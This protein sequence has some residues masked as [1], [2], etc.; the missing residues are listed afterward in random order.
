MLLTIL[1]LILCIVVALAGVPLVTRLVP[2]N[3]VFGLITEKTKSRPEIWYEVNAFAGAALLISA[4]L[5]AILLML[6]NGTW[7]R[8]WWAQ[9]LFFIVMI[10]A[11]VA[12]TL[13]FERRVQKPKRRETSE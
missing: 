4:G 5:T 3:D 8:A 12:A 1:L 6:Y 11:G 2:P 9:I 10:G 7:L 13:V